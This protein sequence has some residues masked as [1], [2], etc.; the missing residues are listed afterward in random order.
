METAMDV[1]VLL[2]HA[3]LCGSAASMASIAAGA[4]NDGRAERRHGRRR[5]PKWVFLE[6][7]VTRLTE[8]VDSS[9]GYHMRAKFS[10]I[11][12]LHR[13]SISRGFSERKLTLQAN[14]IAHLLTCTQFLIEQEHRVLYSSFNS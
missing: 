14:M 13:G 11:A 7:E 10:G 1:A 9:R 3:A 4:R 12:I 8:G 6:K 5:C 2:R